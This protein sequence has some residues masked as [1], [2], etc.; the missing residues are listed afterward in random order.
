MQ[1]WEPDAKVKGL[2][3]RAGSTKTVWAVKARIKGGPP[4]TVT[5]GRVDAMSAV[6]A[7]KKAHQALSLLAEGINPNEQFREEQQ[8][9]QIQQENAAARRMTL[10]EAIEKYLEL[11]NR[12]PATVSSLIQTT[13]RNFEDWLDKPLNGITRE[14]VLRRFKAIK[15]RVIAGN[16]SKSS[17]F[18]NLPGEA[19]AQKA[20]RYLRAICGSFGNDKVGG[21]PLLDGNPVDVLKDKRVRAESTRN[22]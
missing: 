10:R 6:V 22:Q 8:L 18:A 9:K 4:V 11:K 19:E 17:T 3:K 12:K 7:R 2:Y 15:E 5:L 16:R 20:F 1:T 13:H 14:D 21:V